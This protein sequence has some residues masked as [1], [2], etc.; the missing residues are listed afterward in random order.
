[1]QSSTNTCSCCVH[2]VYVCVFVCAGEG[3]GGGCTN[4]AHW[5][6]MPWMSLTTPMLNCPWRLPGVI[7]PGDCLCIAGIVVTF[8][9]YYNVAVAVVSEN[10]DYR[11]VIGQVEVLVSLRVLCT[12]H[13]DI[14]R[15]AGTAQ[16]IKK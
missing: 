1:M 3:G 16:K 12:V 15:V 9:P 10:R 11:L 2:A 8:M 4:S 5:F 7:A 6:G 13:W 14:L